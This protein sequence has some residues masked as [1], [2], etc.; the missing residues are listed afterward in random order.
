MLLYSMGEDETVKLDIHFPKMHN[1]ST[2][3]AEEQSTDHYYVTI[4]N[5]LTGEEQSEIIDYYGLF[6][7]EI[8]VHQS[9]F[10]THS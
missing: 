8:S 4:T 1:Y 2:H 5:T 9:K 6:R 3:E 10:Y 7:R